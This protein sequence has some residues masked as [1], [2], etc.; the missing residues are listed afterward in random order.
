MFQKKELVSIIIAL[1]LTPLTLHAQSFSSGSTGADGA[2]DLSNV[3][4]SPTVF[5]CQIQV[6]E[7][8]I[9]HFT[10]VNIPTGKTL[11]FIP[12]L[13]NTSVII[14]AQGAVTIGGRIEISGGFDYVRQ[15]GQTSAPGPGGFAG[16]GPAFGQ[17]GFG[18]GGGNTNDAHG[19]W[20]GPISLVPIIGGS[21]GRNGLASNSEGGGAGGALVIASSSSIA[22]TQTAVINA[23]GRAG[24]SSGNAFGGGSGGAIRLVANV[25]NVAGTLNAYGSS[26]FPGGHPGVI[27]L[28]APAGS[29]SFTGSANPLPIISTTV[30]PLIVPE[31]TTPSLTI[32]SIGGFPVGYT[33]GRPDVVDLILPN[34]LADPINV[35][36][37]AHNIPIGTKINLN[38]SGSANASYTQGTL[39]GTSTSSSA[40]I[41]VSGLNRIGAT[42]L[43]A[44]ADFTLPASMAQANPKGPNQIAKARVIAKPKTDSKLVFLRSDGT[45]IQLSSVPKT[46][47]QQFGLN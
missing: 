14:L 8:G 29:L 26:D 18:P 11:S 19:R 10:T 6:P 25:V 12:N 9:F 47:Q 21:G 45:E 20:I 32:T 7:S 5:G 23:Q 31:S 36:V 41:P 42:Y 30:N 16:G 24:H 4:C 1:A 33:A 28:E 35:V 38:I 34:Q 44:I 22:F 40:T 37:Q 17:N 3:N 15:L 13:R 46:I 2:L 39:S 27:R 43:I